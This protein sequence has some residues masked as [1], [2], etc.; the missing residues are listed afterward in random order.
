VSN[1]FLKLEELFIN[2]KELLPDNSLHVIKNSNLLLSEDKDI[3]SCDKSFA[4]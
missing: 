3:I 4:I 2:V 1:H